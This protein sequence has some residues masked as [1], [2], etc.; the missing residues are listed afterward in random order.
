MNT[1]CRVVLVIPGLTVFYCHSADSSSRNEL[2]FEIGNE[3]CSL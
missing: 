2:V 1:R 3:S